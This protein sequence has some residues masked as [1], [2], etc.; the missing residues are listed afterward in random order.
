MLKPEQLAL[1]FPEIQTAPR[2]IIARVHRIFANQSMKMGD[3]EWIGFDMDHTIAMYDPSALDSLCIHSMIDRLRQQGFPHAPTNVDPSF[4]IRGLVID[5]RLGHILK[6]DRY[7]VVRKGFHGLRELSPD[8]LAKTYEARRIRVGTPQFFGIDTLY[9]RSEASLFAAWIQSLEQQR[10]S[11]DPSHLFDQI[12]TCADGL[13]RDGTIPRLITD[14]LRRFIRKDPQLASTFHKLRSGG[15]KLFLLTNSPWP[16]T[17]AVMDYLL[18]SEMP[19]YPT[20]RHY[21]DIVITSANKPQ[22]FLERQPLIEQDGDSKRPVVL[23][24][25]TS[26][27]RGKSYEG[28]NLSDFTR[29]LGVPGDRI[30]YVGDHIYGDILRS[31]KEASWRTGLVLHELD[32]E[33]RAH[34]ASLPDI[35][36]LQDLTSQ[37]EEL[38]DE[39]RVHQTLFKDQSRQLE[40]VRATRDIAMTSAVEVQRQLEKRT[41]ERV[42]GLLQSNESETRDIEA[43]IEQ[44]F[45]PTWGPLL[46]EGTELSSFGQ[47]VEA[48]ACVYTSRVSNL[49]FYS[50]IQHFR[51][52]RD[53]MPHE[54]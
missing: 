31:K 20:W 54:F 2:T 47:Q 52:P 41:V 4:C 39:L 42:R 26:F 27:E 40:S 44:R 51:S 14:D 6:L 17:H 12:R 22:F 3:V 8:Q 25:S 11:I 7:R 18:G 50:P 49:L 32:D 13:F 5:K 24:A 23:R 10:H 37:R 29:L 30:L 1:P 28:G 38:E 36:R 33:L 45:H 15:K 48:Y 34:E 16:F 19:E 43:R 46:K 53:L 9:A 21:F 35:Q